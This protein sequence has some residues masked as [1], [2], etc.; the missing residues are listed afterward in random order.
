MDYYSFLQKENTTI[1]NIY[2]PNIGASTCK[3]QILTGIKGGID[4][5]LQQWGTL[6]ATYINGEI[7]QTENQ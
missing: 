6:T 4:G 3:K 5:S 1:V 7:I 2:V